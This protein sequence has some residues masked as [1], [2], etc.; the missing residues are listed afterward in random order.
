MKPAEETGISWYADIK[1]G[2]IYGKRM[3]MSPIVLF[4]QD[5]VTVLLHALLFDKEIDGVRAT[6]EIQNRQPS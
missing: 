4:D 2:T 3:K 5:D 1:S 6:V